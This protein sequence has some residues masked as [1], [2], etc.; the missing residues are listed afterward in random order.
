MGK[1]RRLTLTV[2]AGRVGQKV[3]TVMRGGMGLSGTVIRR[4]KWLEDGIL[5]DGVRVFTNVRVREG[6]VLSV[7]LSESQRRSGIVPAP[8][9]LEIVREDEDILVINKAPGV[10]VHPGPGHYDDTIG[11]FVMNYYEKQGIEADFHPVHRLDRGTSGL[12]VI[13][14]H[15]HAQEVLKNRL[16]TEDFQRIY[17]AVCMGSPPCREGEVDVPLGPVEGSLM[18]R[19]VRPDGAPARTG[20]R[21]LCR[22]G[23]RSLVRLKLFTGRTHQIRVHMAY[24]GCPLAGDFLYGVEDKKLIGRTAL[25]SAQLE[26]VHPVTGERLSFQAPLPEDMRRLVED[27]F[28]EKP[29]RD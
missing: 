3:D 25:H 12:M 1:P 5:L 19:Q 7:R 27:S 14:K 26:L 21:V 11:N 10:A 23:G 13:A 29:V 17:L 8:G 28:P 16:H 15:P 6:Q 20:Y 18:A 22:E 2:E 24:L 4:A 9:S